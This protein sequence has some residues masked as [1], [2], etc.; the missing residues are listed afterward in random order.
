MN[1]SNP[2]LPL[3]SL[4]LLLQLLLVA[5]VTAPS[6]ARAETSICLLR[7]ES[8]LKDQAQ[9]DLVSRILTRML[10]EQNDVRVIDRTDVMMSDLL[11][12]HEC[13]EED[14]SCLTQVAESFDAQ[15]VL[16]GKVE[17]FADNV[18]V[19][20][21]VFD[22]ESSAIRPVYSRR[23]AQDDLSNV[24]GADLSDL[25]GGELWELPG[26]LSLTSLETAAVTLDKQDLGP[27]P[28][29]R[30]R[31]QPGTHT[32]QVTAPGH[33]PW[34][35]N[36][37]FKPGRLV[38]L[39][40]DLR[41]KENVV[42]IIKT[43]DSLND[44]S[45]L[46]DP[47]D[48][49]V[50]MEYHSPA[51]AWVVLGLG[52]ACLTASVVT[53]ILTLKTQGEFNDERRPQ[54]AQDLTDRGEMLAVTTSVLIAVGASGVVTSGLMFAFLGEWTESDPLQ[55]GL[56]PTLGGGYMELQLRF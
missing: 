27:P 44:P 56:A 1:L 4:R 46:T 32:I 11:L 40:V 31:V 37:E 17:I 53:G 34:E 19:I 38:E 54:Q 35:Q 16:Y 10:G 55:I 48:D 26:Y 39:N 49:E 7:L 36:V 42:V 41:A 13:D 51:S 25:V 8:E 24:L 3:P 23:I 22:S 5:L 6:L 28:L 47:F 14:V 30:V 18:L 15:Q 45:L 20:L 9:A 21:R 33:N 52:G 50:M 2:R 12:V 29:A 43:D